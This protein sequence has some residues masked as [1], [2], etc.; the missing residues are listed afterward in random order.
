MYLH[1]VQVGKVL[2]LPVPNHMPSKHTFNLYRLKIL[3]TI[4]SKI[5]LLAYVEGMILNREHAH[6]WPN[7][8]AGIQTNTRTAGLLIAMIRSIYSIESQGLYLQLHKEW[9]MNKRHQS[10]QSFSPTCNLYKVSRTMQLA[11][12]MYNLWELY[13]YLL[14]LLCFISSA[15]VWILRSQCITQAVVKLGSIAQKTAEHFIP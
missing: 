9:G 12:T 4:F 15:P 10:Q 6:A 13:D 14:A 8:R 11:Q 2:W 7:A 3:Y 1:H 5:R